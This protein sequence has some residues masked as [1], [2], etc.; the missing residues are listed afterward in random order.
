MYPGCAPHP[1]ENK[2][3]TMACVEPVQQSTGKPVS[4]SS[5]RVLIIDDNK[6]IHNDFRKILNPDAGDAALQSLE[7]EIF[8]EDENAGDS[9]I[10]DPTIT[11][12]LD[13]AHQGK[14]GYELAKQALANGQPYAMAFVDMR[15][16]PGW[17]GIETIKHIWADDPNLQIVICTA[18]SDHTWQDIHKQFG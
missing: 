6:A 18:Y 4:E 2:T 5:F 1:P 13:S 3:L 8:G 17:D 10:N 11:F 15:M 7:D 16:P 12:Q 9:M 14:E